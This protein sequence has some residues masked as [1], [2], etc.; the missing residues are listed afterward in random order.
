[1]LRRTLLHFKPRRR[2]HCFCQTAQTL[3]QMGRGG[4]G[5]GRPLNSQ[6]LFSKPG[7]MPENCVIVIST[8][9]SCGSMCSMAAFC[10]GKKSC[11]IPGIKNRKVNPYELRGTHVYRLFR[12]LLLSS[13]D[14]PPNYSRLYF[15]WHPLLKN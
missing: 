14:V 6:N 8:I 2:L 12:E 1:M 7:S 10:C 3:Q 11:G 13:K 9:S 5:G 15:I 4:R